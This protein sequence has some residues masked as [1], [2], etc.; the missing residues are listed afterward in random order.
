MKVEIKK[1]TPVNNWVALK[2]PELSKFKEEESEKNNTFFDLKEVKPLQDK[3]KVVTAANKYTLYEVAD[4][5]NCAFLEA[6]QLILVDEVGVCALPDYNTYIV[7]ASYVVGIV[8]EDEEA[9]A[10]EVEF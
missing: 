8:S 3:K 6:G 5:G 1:I 7:P 9:Q 10:V 4:N 2:L